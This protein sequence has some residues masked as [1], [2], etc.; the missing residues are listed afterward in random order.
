[1]LC[2]AIVLSLTPMERNRMQYGYGRSPRG[3]RLLTV[4]ARASRSDFNAT[5]SPEMRCTLRSP[6][7]DVAMCRV[8]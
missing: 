7:V 4:V 5:E 3:A 2:V 6:V 8:L 1:V